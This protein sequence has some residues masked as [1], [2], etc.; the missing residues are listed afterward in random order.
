MLFAVVLCKCLCIMGEYIDLAVNFRSFHAYQGTRFSFLAR[1][2]V[3]QIGK[4][5]DKGQIT[6]GM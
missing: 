4:E 2:I 1:E 3:L 5:C 6:I